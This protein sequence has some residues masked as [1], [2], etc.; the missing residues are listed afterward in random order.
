MVYDGYPIIITYLVTND[1]NL[2]GVIIKRCS[3]L[4][5]MKHL[6][7]VIR[8][9]YVCKLFTVQKKET[10]KS[11]KFKFTCMVTQVHSLPILKPLPIPM[12]MSLKSN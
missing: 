4:S 1:S 3:A 11:G 6:N 8:V 9:E 2:E 10:R 5:R 7:I 12:N